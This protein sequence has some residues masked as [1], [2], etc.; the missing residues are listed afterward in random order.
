MALTYIT[1]QGYPVTNPKFN[2]QN[3]TYV[4]VYADDVTKQL[5]FIDEKTA[6][7]L[8]RIPSFGSNYLYFEATIT[9]SGTN[10]PVITV[11]ENTLSLGP[12][13]GTYVT[14]GK[15]NIDFGTLISPISN[16]N[17]LS[18]LFGVGTE[19][20]PLLATFK[21]LTATSIRIESYVAGGPGFPSLSDDKFFKTALQIKYYL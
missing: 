13:V 3:V 4:D 21:P 14:L 11:L 19:K 2:S 18:V 6:T 20:F 7:E 1:K 5:V 12:V 9:Q 10:A 17:R 16:A 8:Y 15:Y